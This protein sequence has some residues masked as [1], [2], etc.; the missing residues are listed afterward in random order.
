MPV[1][2]S[3]FTISVGSGIKDESGNESDGIK[4]FRI[5]ANGQ[6]SKPP[7]LL[8]IRMPMAPANV[9]SAGELPIV[10]TP[11]SLFDDIPITEEPDHY[12]YEAPVST[13]IDLYFDTASAL[14]LFSLMDKFR[15]EATNSAMSFSPQ[16]VRDSNFTWAAAEDAWAQAY[17]VEIRGNLTNTVNSGVV[18]FMAAS[19][20]SDVLGNTS[21]SIFR[22][23][24]LK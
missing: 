20:L 21:E 2:G 16:S 7:S 13:C 5:Y 17:R 8:G 3:H 14:N 9:N 22:I 6:Y 15:V 18:T 12:P 10:Y 24:L 23:P 11:S 1:Y 4:L 19:E